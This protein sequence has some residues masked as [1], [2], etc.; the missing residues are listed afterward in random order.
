MRSLQRKVEAVIGGKVFKWGSK[1]LVEEANL[2]QK[3]IEVGTK[4][5]TVNYYERNLQEL[6]GNASHSSS[7]ASAPPQ[8]T[9]LLCHGMTDES[10]SM[11]PMLLKVKKQID[12]NWRVII[13]DLIGHGKDLERAN[14]VGVKN[15]DYPTPSDLV[16]SMDDFLTALKIKEC[17]AFGISLG[18]ALVYYLQQKRPDVIK[19]SVLVSPAVEAVVD[20]MFINDFV[21]GRKNH[22]C[23]ESRHD[24]KILMRDLSC[25]QRKHNNPVPK[26]FLEAVWQDRL[27]REPT[28]HFRT[29]FLNLLNHRGKDPE[30]W[31]S[32]LDLAPELPR[33][34]IW[35]QEDY[36]ANHDK[37]K[38]FFSQSSN[39]VFHSLPDSG[40]LFLAD[41]RTVLE[42][43]APMMMDYF[44]EDDEK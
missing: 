19:K 33:L 22:F 41:R 30:Y 35:P 3:E 8:P 40:H 18:G 39:T 44:K 9:L 1:I 12:P 17:Y 23:F 10:L 25:P 31:G 21:Q 13:P 32:P 11:A 14:K 36:I 43:A 15:F 4:G 42:Y 34:V 27:S 6:Y 20:E 37:G 24:V 7:N 2:V 38:T 16:Q 5:L 26:F 28:G 29:Y